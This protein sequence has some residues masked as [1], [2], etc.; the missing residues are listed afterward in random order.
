MSPLRK[1]YGRMTPTAMREGP[2]K[3]DFY[4]IDC[5]EKPHVHVRSSDGVAKIWLI[6]VSTAWARWSKKSAGRAAEKF[7]T[8]HV[9]ELLSQWERHCGEKETR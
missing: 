2:F 1:R 3:A 9:V 7:V 8:N 4:S 6:P 5:A